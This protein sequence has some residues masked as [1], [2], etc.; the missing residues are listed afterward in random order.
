MDWH[1]LPPA[2]DALAADVAV[3]AKGRF[4]GDPSHQ[5]EH[6]ETRRRGDGDDAAEGEVTVSQIVTTAYSPNNNKVK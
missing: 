2:T 5:Y 6:T 1:L 4:I 3:A